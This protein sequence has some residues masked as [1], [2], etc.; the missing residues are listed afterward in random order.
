MALM[1]RRAEFPPAAPWS[2]FSRVQGGRGMALAD[3]RKIVVQ[4]DETLVEMG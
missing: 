4:V 3:I 2:S 1:R